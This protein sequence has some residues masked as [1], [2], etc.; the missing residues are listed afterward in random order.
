M[1][2]QSEANGQD[3]I[4]DITFLLGANLAANFKIND[5]TRS[6]NEWQNIVWTWIFESYGGWQFMDDASSGVTGN[7]TSGTNDVPYADQ[8]ITSGT[9]LLALPTGTLTVVG[10]QMKS[11]SGGTF[12]PLQPLT[13]EE[14]L[15]RGGDGAFPST[16]VPSFYMLQGDILRLLPSPNFTLSAALRV[17]FDQAMVNFAVTDTTKVPGFASIFHRIL[18]I[19]PSLDYAMV[20]GTPALVNQLTALKNDYQQRIK[21]FYSKR[22]KDRFPNRINTGEDLAS[23]FA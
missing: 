11:V 22:Y 17:V 4:A 6:V 14:F 9:P 16:G 13:Y 19:G 3:I 20:R 1:Q 18:S 2:Y 8:T 15:D 12:S 21:S 5:R 23:E 7:V 10:V